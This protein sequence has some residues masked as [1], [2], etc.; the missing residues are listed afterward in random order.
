MIPVK[1]SALILTRAK[2]SVYKEYY[3]N[4][5]LY[6]KNR[7]K[8]ILRFGY[9]RTNMG[10]EV[11]EERA[12]MDFFADGVTNIPNPYSTNNVCIARA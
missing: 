9:S 7:V 5:F 6:L 2:A 4:L 11:T 3:P 10:R 8:P 1:R 12:C